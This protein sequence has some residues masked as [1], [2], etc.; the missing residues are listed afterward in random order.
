MLDSATLLLSLYMQSVN[1]LKH[2]ELDLVSGPQLRKKKVLII[3]HEGFR[4]RQKAS[5]T[6]RRVEGHRNLNT[7]SV[8]QHHAIKLGLSDMHVSSLAIRDTYIGR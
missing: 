1:K 4:Y 6:V 3:R 8:L 5:A 2:K 7:V